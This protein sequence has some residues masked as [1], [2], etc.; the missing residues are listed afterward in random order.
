M[1]NANFVLESR[2]STGEHYVLLRSYPR[3]GKLP[4]QQWEWTDDFHK[5]STFEGQREIERL[6]AEHRCPVMMFRVRPYDAA[7]SDYLKH[8]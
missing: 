6:T 5:A 8:K 2:F 3:K 1:E 4:R 7:L